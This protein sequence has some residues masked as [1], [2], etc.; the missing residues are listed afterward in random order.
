M[1][2]LFQYGSNC[3]SNRLNA[4]ERLSGAATNPRL[5]RTV[6][7]YGI[8]LN[9]WSNGNGRAASN[10]RPATDRHAWGVLYDIADDRL[11][12]RGAADRKT[13]EQIEGPRY[14]ATT[15]ISV[16]LGG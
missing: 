11:T 12:G 14:E 1:A 8:A 7:V 9:V 2:V 4:P 6:H 5:A 10:L 15:V 3:D 13:M 16:T